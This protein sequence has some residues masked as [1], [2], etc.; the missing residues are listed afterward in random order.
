MFIVLF[1]SFLVGLELNLRRH[2]FTKKVSITLSLTILRFLE[3]S[4][5]LELLIKL[6]EDVWFL[7]V[8]KKNE[9]ATVIC[10]QTV[11]KGGW[12]LKNKYVTT[13]NC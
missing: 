10:T 9:R 3:M 2:A 12:Y 8:Y 1:R 6:S 5:N 13:Y 4:H 11:L 7:G